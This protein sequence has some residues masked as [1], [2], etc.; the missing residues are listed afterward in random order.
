[1]IANRSM[2]RVSKRLSSSARLGEEYS[3]P[4]KRRTPLMGA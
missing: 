3:N 4:R 1:M 2:G